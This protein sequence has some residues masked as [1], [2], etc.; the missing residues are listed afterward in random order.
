VYEYRIKYPDKAVL[1]SA[2]GYD[3]FGWAV[4]MAGGSL[5][6]LPAG[7]DKQFLTAAS[8]MKPLELPASPK[9]QWALSSAKD[10]I[11]YTNADGTVRLNLP[12]NSSYQAQW[13]DSQSGQVLP[14]NQ[15]V[16]GGNATEI[17]NPNGRAAILWLTRN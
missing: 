13:I 15:Q 1:Y 5:P 12:A 3:R 7:T 10:Y 16:N 4:F 8:G 6:V 17:K 9:D 14:G 11:V 2:D